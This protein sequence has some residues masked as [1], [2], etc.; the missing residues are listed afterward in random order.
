MVRF[1]NTRLLDENIHKYSAIL[2]GE[3]S[4][5]NRDSNIEFVCICGKKYIKKFRAIIDHSGAYCKD[6]TRDNKIKN[7]Q[8]TFIEKY[9]ETTPLKCESTKNK[10]KETLLKSYG[11]TNPLHNKDILKK[12]Q[13][14]NIKKYGSISPGSNSD[15][16]NKI[17]KTNIIR[18][19][20]P[21]HMQ[22]ENILKKT[23]T[24]NLIRYGTETTFLNKDISDKRYNTN[25]S[26]YG[27]KVSLQNVDVQQKVQKSSTK[28][29]NYICP[30]G[31]TRRIQGYENFALDILLKIYTEDQIKT[32]RRDIGR[33]KYND[34]GKI[35]YYFPDIKIPHI[36]KIIEVKCE[37][38]YK[39]DYLINMLKADATRKCGYDFE[40]W[41]FD[42]H[43]NLIDESLL[44]CFNP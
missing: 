30:S 36:N 5:L 7:Q 18:Y 1:F 37:W 8:K 40:F 14:T 16:K 4:N 12:V 13:E 38:T 42:K 15:V 9:G 29:K 41:I 28:Y 2:I 22:N 34:N 32:D 23:R 27:V 10:I 20:V 6:C 43:G 3:Y 44:T 24:T 26:R 31:I 33:I 35:R 21:H 25:I 39:S 19:G 17:R 11:V